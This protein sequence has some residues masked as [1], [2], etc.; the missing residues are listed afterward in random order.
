MDISQSCTSS[1]EEFTMLINN[2][3]LVPKIHMRKQKI[4]ETLTLKFFHH[5]IIRY[6]F[7]QQLKQAGKLQLLKGYM[8]TS[9]S[10]N[11]LVSHHRNFSRLSMICT[12]EINDLSSIPGVQGQSRKKGENGC[13]HWSTKDLFQGLL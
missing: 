5:S 10:P 4:Q 9:L 11:T 12:P 7:A 6:H 3:S 13:C 8:F 1:S 2:N